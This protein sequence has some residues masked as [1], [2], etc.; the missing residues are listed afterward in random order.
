V[1]SA[2]RESLY[3]PRHFDHH[4][5]AQR[6]RFRHVVAQE[7]LGGFGG[8]LAVGGAPPSSVGNGKRIGF[9][10]LRAAQAAGFGALGY[11]VFG[12][13]IDYGPRGNTWREGYANDFLAPN[14][15]SSFP[16]NRQGSPAQCAPVTEQAAVQVL[17]VAVELV[18][19]PRL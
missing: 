14:R 16:I 7:L 11:L 18:T 1:G 4:A 13:V 8:D 12:S 6:A 5:N 9:R 17:V 2:A 3:L 15:R 10:G 19:G